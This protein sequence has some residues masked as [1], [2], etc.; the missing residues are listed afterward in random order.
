LE[1]RKGTYPQG[2]LNGGNTMTDHNN[3]DV[4][5][6]FHLGWL[7]MVPWQRRE[8]SAAVAE[9]VNWCVNDP[10]GSIRDDGTLRSPDQSDPIPD[11]FYYAASFL[12]TV[13]YFETKKR[14]WTADPVPGDPVKITRGMIEQLKKFNPY[15]TEVDDTLTRLGAAEHP[16]TSAIL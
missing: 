7:R 12:D 9:L 8:A 11:S 2:W 3:Y 4:A 10:S 13:G 15:Y 5:E 6:L 14:F 16:W 1:M